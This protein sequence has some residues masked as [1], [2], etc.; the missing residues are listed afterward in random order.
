MKMIARMLGI[1]FVVLSLS[2]CG[3]YL[4]DQPKVFGVK[5]FIWWHL[6]QHQ[7]ELA[8]GNLTSPTTK[9]VNRKE[10]AECMNMCV[11]KDNSDSTGVSRKCFNK[12]L[13]KITP[14][15]KGYHSST[16]V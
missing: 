4:Y 14:V 15:P 1:G 11:P 13:K 3:A 2:S 10:F 16:P 12:C 5:D 6:S 7:R 8:V 9:S